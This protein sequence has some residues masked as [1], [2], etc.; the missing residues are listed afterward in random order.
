M[1]FYFQRLL[2]SLFPNTLKQVPEEFVSTKKV[3][4]TWS[5]LLYFRKAFLNH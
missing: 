2:R 5:P 1:E 4:Q 3:I